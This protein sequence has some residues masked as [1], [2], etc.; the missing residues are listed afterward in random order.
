MCP[1]RGERDWRCGPSTA[2]RPAAAAAR[3]RGRPQV[4]PNDEPGT[5][6]ARPLAARRRGSPPSP[7]SSRAPP[8][9][10]SAA[11]AARPAP[12]TRSPTSAR[13]SRRE[14]A[15]AARPRAARRRPRRRSPSRRSAPHQDRAQV[16]QPEHQRQPQH[17]VELVHVA[18]RRQ[19]PVQRVVQP[20]RGHA[21]DR[22]QVARRDQ[23]HPGQDAPAPATAARAGRGGRSAARPAAARTTV[24]ATGSGVVDQRPPR[25]PDRAGGTS[26]AATQC[27]VPRSTLER[28]RS[29]RWWSPR[30]RCSPGTAGCTGRAAA[31]GR[32]TRRWPARRPRPPH[33][34]A[35]AARPGGR[36]SRNSAASGS[37]AAVADR[38]D[39]AHA[40]HRQ[41]RPR[42]RPPRRAGSA[43][44]TS[45]TSTHGASAI[46]STSTEIAPSEVTIRG[47]SA[48]ATPAT[49]AVA[50]VPMPQP[51]RQA[52]HARGTPRSAAAA[53]TA[54][55]P[56][57]PA[58]PA[59]SR[60][61]R[62][63][64][65]GT[66]S[67]RPG[68]AAL[69]GEAL[70]VPQ[71]QRPAQEPHGSTTR[72]SLV[73]PTTL[74]GRC[75]TDRTTNPRQT[76]PGHAQRRA[77][78]GT[79]ARGAAPAAFRRGRGRPGPRPRDGGRHADTACS[80][81]AGPASPYVTP[82]AGP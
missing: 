3:R 19:R 13:T 78:P 22:G 81:T 60:A 7:A 10:R 4:V 66:G 37:T 51:A 2:T 45:G 41:P 76:S 34:S 35:A 70:R 39:P 59:T 20:A 38:V 69:A 68:S 57:R 30:S 15:R 5:S 53:T 64:P 26:R 6:S 36:V 16:R 21:V 71:R 47:A 72:S 65:S 8:R 48:Y 62:T 54:A 9:S 25:R 55:G 82:C 33:R 61:R 67:R 1:S 11:P 50:G 46:G 63:G 14:D 79:T 23:R 75:R 43:A 44:P 31:A 80:A 27:E 40:E 58:G 28:R 24:A 32:P 73:S 52:H 49:S 77:A 42:R 12:G 18:Q 56:A 29:A 17:R 74:P